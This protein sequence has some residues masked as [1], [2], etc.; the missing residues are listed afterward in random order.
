MN[1]VALVSVERI[2]TARMIAPLIYGITFADEYMTQH[3]R[4]RLM[5]VGPFLDAVFVRHY[6]LYWTHGHTLSYAFP[7]ALLNRNFGLISRI[8]QLYSRQKDD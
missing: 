5:N 6:F 4:I 8:V 1:L 3:C 7:D 2:H